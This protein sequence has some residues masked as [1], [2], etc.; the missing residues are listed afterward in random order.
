MIAFWNKISGF[1]W[2]LGLI[3]RCNIVAIV[4]DYIVEIIVIID[5]FA[6]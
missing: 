4:I 6:Y 2:L 5:L 3:S 1:K